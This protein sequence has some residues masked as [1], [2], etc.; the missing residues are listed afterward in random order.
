MRK[1]LSGRIIK[2]IGGY[3]TVDDGSA[4]YICRARGRF[5]KDG[6]SP[7]VGDYVVFD[8]DDNGEGYLIEIAGRKNEL[9]RPPVAN[10]DLLIIVIAVH[11]PEPDF[12]MVDRLLV[13]ASRMDMDVA[14]CINK[15]DL[16][17]PGEV[18]ENFSQYRFLDSKFLVSARDGDGVDEIKVLSGS[19]T[20]CLA[21]QSGVGKSSI[22]NRL[23]PGADF[24]TGD[25]S[26]KIDRGRHTTRMACLVPSGQGGYIVDTPGFSLLDLPMMEPCELR[27]DYRDFHAYNDCCRF[28]GCLHDREP[29]CA[30]KDAVQQGLIDGRRYG[31]YVELL[32]EIN[33]KWENR[34]D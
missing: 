13:N 12:L 33:I 31:R 26:G 10:M 22:I 32:K 1:G 2:G 11:M 28:Q 25:L 24:E 14:L 4:E 30:V 18:E 17:R 23:V 9:A 20:V 19:R 16:A 15:S 27:H 21:G 29:G 6:V 8:A 5:R 3:Y 34:Y 7:K